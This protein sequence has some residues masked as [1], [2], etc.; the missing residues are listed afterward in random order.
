MKHTTCLAAWG[1]WWDV[2]TGVIR[3]QC[4]PMVF[5]EEEPALIFPAGAKSIEGAT[6]NHG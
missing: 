4:A 3:H 5:A 1:G 6:F 2:Q